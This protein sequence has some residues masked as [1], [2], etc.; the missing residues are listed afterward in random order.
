MQFGQDFDIPPK[1]IMLTT[2]ISVLEKNFEKKNCLGLK[3][4]NLIYNMS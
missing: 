3:S 1:K 4:T 2:L